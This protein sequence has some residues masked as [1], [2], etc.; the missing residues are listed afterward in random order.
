MGL[1]LDLLIVFLFALFILIG[2]K[3][4][5]I[6]TLVG[7]IG[8]FGALI[9]ASLLARPVAGG[10]FD[11]F[12]RAPLHT[13]VET[14]LVKAGAGQATES[15]AALLKELPGFLSAYIKGNDLQGQL[16]G[17]LNS[18]MASAANTV[19]ELISPLF[20]S[21]LSLIAFFVLYLIVRLAVQLFSKVI[22]G[23]FKAP[24]LGS[25]NSVLGGILGAAQAFL[26]CLLAGVLIY[27]LNA[28]GALFSA[29]TLRDSTLFASFCSSQ[30]M[31]V[32]LFSGF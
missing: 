19:V 25:V 27:L 11:L 26:F 10:V 7:F 4:G 29:E 24:V 31:I 21:F 18:G 1:F 23:I 17:A 20:I 2:V 15:V 3:R 32:Q 30:N 22:E 16:E 6:K 13:T 12:F 9:A 8:S 14:A 28:D 5:F